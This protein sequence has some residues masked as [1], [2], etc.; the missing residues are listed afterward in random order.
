MADATDIWTTRLP[1][2]LSSVP[3]ARHFA[4]DVCVA[5]GC[6]DWCEHVQL[7]VSELATNVVCHAHT[8]MRVSFL[9]LEDRLRVEVRDD[10]PTPPPVSG[11]PPDLEAL[12]GRGIYLLAQL[13]TSWGVN[14]DE[15]G[16]TIW[17]ELP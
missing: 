11:E 4:S 7:L 1:P 9:R 15:R 16:K 5:M 2:V 17:F 13:A 14:S 3:L 12:G 6:S 8:P 10:D